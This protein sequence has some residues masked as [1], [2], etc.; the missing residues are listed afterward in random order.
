MKLFYYSINPEI[1]SEKLDIENSPHIMKEKIGDWGL[2]KV[3]S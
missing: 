1:L 2:M 3:E